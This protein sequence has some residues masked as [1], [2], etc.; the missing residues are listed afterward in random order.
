MIWSWKVILLAFALASVLVEHLIHDQTLPA[1]QPTD[2]NDGSVKT[3]SVPAHEE[4]LIKGVLQPLVVE[5][6]ALAFCQIVGVPVAVK[7]GAI[8]PRIRVLRSVTTRFSILRRARLPLVRRIQK[9]IARLYKNRQRLSA[10]S[11]ITH[12]MG[13]EEGNLNT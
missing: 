3:V 11:D 8:L 6:G 9:S 2:Q 12:L 7:L 13:D 5:A 4:I 1:K 10:A